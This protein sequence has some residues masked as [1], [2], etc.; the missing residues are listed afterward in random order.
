MLVPIR[1]SHM[2]AQVLEEGQNGELSMGGAQFDW[3]KQWYPLAVAD[4]LDPTRPH[5]QLL[6]GMCHHNKAENEVAIG[7]LKHEWPKPST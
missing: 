5:A 4:D 7:L 2:Y 1:R 3:V 6:L